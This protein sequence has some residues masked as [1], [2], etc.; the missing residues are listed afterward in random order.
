[1]LGKRTLAIFISSCVISMGLPHLSHAESMNQE[2][3][4]QLMYSKSQPPS[5]L[6]MT[7]DLLVARPLLVGAT[8][9]GA[10]VFVVSLPFS[11]LGNN[12]ADAADKLVATPGKAAFFRCLGCRA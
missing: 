2:Q 5:T 1:M 8:A 9:L 7:A 6:S 11:L 10:A 12:V 3:Y 4:E